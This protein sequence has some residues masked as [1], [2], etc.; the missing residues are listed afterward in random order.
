MEEDLK[1]IVKAVFLIIMLFVAPLIA[2][3][4]WNNILV[5]LCHFEVISY[6]Q[7]FFIGVGLRIIN[8]TLSIRM[9]ND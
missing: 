8:G 1:Q 7:M 9:K 2:M 3:L 4:V 5:K 6:W